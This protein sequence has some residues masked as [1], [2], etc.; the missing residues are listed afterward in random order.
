M[1]PELVCFWLAVTLY[2]V[3]TFSYIFGLIA[4]QEKLFTIGLLDRKS[5]V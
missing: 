4:R 1:K 3:S 2:G 5:V